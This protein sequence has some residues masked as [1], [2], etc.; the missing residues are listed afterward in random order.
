[1]KSLRV[2]VHSV[3]VWVNDHYGVQQIRLSYPLKPG[4]TRWEY[5]FTTASHELNKFGLKPMNVRRVSIDAFSIEADVIMCRGDVYGR[6]LHN[7][8]KSL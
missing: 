7:D 8:Q 6:K 3:C 2:L 5:V 4:A 1:M